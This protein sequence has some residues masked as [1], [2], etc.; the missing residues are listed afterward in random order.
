MNKKMSLDELFTMLQPKFKEFIL[1]TDDEKRQLMEVVEYIKTKF[2]DF[3]VSIREVERLPTYV[4]Y[5]ILFGLKRNF[6]WSTEVL[7]CSR[8]EG[9]S[10][11]CKCI[12]DDL[13]RE[14]KRKVYR[15]NEP[16]CSM[17]GLNIICDIE[18]PERTLIVHPSVFEFL[19]KIINDG[20][21]EE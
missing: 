10:L 7:R 8:F 11:A 1:S 20:S 21:G 14:I 15:T 19:M 16:I 5:E 3:Y 13:F 9:L 2:T 4:E 12:V 17:F 6:I 18:L